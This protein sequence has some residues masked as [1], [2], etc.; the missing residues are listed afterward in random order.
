MSQQ[1]VKPI[2]TINELSV[3]FPGPGGKRNRA[4]DNVNLTVYPRQ[5]LAVV[6][7][8]GSGKS[9]SA[10]SILQLIPTPPGSYDR[11]SINWQPDAADP[12]VDLLQYND[13]QMRAIRGNQIAMIFQEP[14]TSLNPVYTIG[15][16]IIEAVRL[17]QNVT[18][19]QSID[20]AIKAL[21][22]VGIAAPESRLKEY[23]HQL[24]GGMRQRV[25]IAMA[26][27]CQPKLLLADE[28]TTAL[29]VTIQAQILELLR[30]LQDTKDMGIILITHDL[31][32]VAENADVVAVMYAGR[33]CEFA[34]VY[35]IF[36]RPLHPYTRGLLRSM[37]V[38]GQEVTRLPTVTDGATVP[39]D[40]PSGYNVEPHVTTPDP[41]VGYGGKD[42]RLYEVE[43]NHWVLCTPQPGNDIQSSHPGRNFRREPIA[44]S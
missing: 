36:D 38:L 4:V 5:T 35:D 42:A 43:P 18:K 1:E 10:M 3:S 21:T 20:I 7:E 37:P 16:Q 19:A 33:V 41:E 27:A 34:S 26:L 12:P 24:S 32:V 40:F 17:H 11:G 6:G 31:G 25:M 44:H 15:D 28:P 23:P 22:D 13:K 8:S 29:D 30:H 14:M 2:L 9:V 39:E